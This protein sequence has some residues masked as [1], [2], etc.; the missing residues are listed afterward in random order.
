MSIARKFSD[1]VWLGRS[2]GTY[3]ESGSGYVDLA[4]KNENLGWASEDLLCA[5]FVY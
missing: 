4:G 3:R 1:T 5:M 2:S